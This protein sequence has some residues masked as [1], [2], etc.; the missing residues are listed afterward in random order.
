MS[1]VD[2]RFWMICAQHIYL[3]YL[4]INFI[5]LWYP[6][7]SVPFQLLKRHDQETVYLALL[8]AGRQGSKWQARWQN[9]MLSAH[10]PYYEPEAE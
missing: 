8:T 9:G 6:G 7:T 10:N 3:N 5:F 1:P 4:L 2:P